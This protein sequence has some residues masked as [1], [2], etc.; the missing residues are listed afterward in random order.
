[1]L[2]DRLIAPEGPL[3]V[4]VSELENEKNLTK[5]ELIAIAVNNACDVLAM[6]LF[7]SSLIV[8]AHHLV[9][10]AQN[11]VNAWYG[12]YAQARS[13][14]V[15]IAIFA[16]GQNQIGKALDTFGVK[17]NLK[18][19]AVVIISNDKDV[20][21]RC[22]INLQEKV[23]SPLQVQFAS[24]LCRFKSI[25]R[26]F[27]INEQELEAIS[28]GVGAISTREALLRCVA[29]RVSTVALEA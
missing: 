11:A 26:V 8:D 4:G 22:L 16:S 10:A 6:Q 19:I 2:V 9:V 17:D 1:M 13:L 18:Q 29:S 14:D 25:M 27:D 3:F 7:D 21:R 24:D 12:K 5:D 28:E 15:E 23:G 20:I